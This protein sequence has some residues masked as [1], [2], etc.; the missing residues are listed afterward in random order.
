MEV[1]AACLVAIG[2]A[3]A[4]VTEVPLTGEAGGT[5]TAGAV[6]VVDQLQHTKPNQEGHTYVRQQRWYTAICQGVVPVAG[7][8]VTEEATFCATAGGLSQVVL[9][10]AVSQ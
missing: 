4:G 10:V 7:G 8:T 5:D 3:G 9:L 1:V 2:T 6:D